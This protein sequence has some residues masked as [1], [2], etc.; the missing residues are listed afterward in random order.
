MTDIRLSSL[1]MLSIEAS[2]VRS[3]DLDDVKG[4][5]MPKDSLQV[6]LILLQ[7]DIVYD[8]FMVIVT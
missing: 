1:A 5:C 8:I 7:S 3:L 6:V 4:F 2:C